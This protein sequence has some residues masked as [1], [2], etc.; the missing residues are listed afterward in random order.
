MDAQA[1]I[2]LVVLAFIGLLQW[3]SYSNKVPPTPSRRDVRAA[4]LALLDGANPKTIIDLGSGWGGMAVRLSAVFPHAKVIGY[5]GSWLP[6]IWSR[7]FA[8]R[9]ITFKRADFY[10]TSLSG[11]DIIYCYL[12]P[13]HMEKLVSKFDVELKAGTLVVSASF[14]ILGR[15]PL[16]QAII[17]GIVDIPVYLYR[18]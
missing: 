6:Y 15:T 3:Q 13:W 14:P 16:K 5:E 9:G 12:T 8:G 2:M 10:K 4:A 1:L 7:L 18:W 17:K 11:A